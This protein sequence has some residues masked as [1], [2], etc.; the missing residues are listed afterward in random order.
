MRKILITG[1]GSFIGTSFENYIK[2]HEKHAEYEISVMDTLT[3]KLV[4]G[5]S[6]DIWNFD[7]YD[8][9]F[10]VAGIAH[11]KDVPDSLYEEVNYKL[12]VD[13]ARKAQEDG[14][15]QFVFMSSGAVYSQNDRRHRMIAVDVLY[16]EDSLLRLPALDLYA[17]QPMGGGELAL[18]LASIGAE[19]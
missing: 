3:G 5:E 10:H 2:S 19:G 9:V 16:V 4:G 11:Q 6:E 14:V 7:G 17:I 15:K 13:V 8:T 18:C 12:A 1:A